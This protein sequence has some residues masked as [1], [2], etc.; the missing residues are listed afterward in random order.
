VN[1]RLP[2]IFEPD[3]VTPAW[4]REA[5]GRAVECVG[6]ELESIGTGQVGAN[7]RAHL[8][9]EDGD[10]PETVVIKFAASDSQS[11]STG[12][13]MGTYRREAEFYRLL[14]PTIEV[15]VPYVYFVDFVPGTADV[16]I[17]MED[18]EPRKQGDQLQGC[19]PEEAALA[20]SEAAKLH[21]AFWGKPELFDLDWVSRRTPEQ[22]TQ[23]IELMEILQPAFV[24]RYRRE[25]TEEAID[26]SDRFVRNASQWFSGLP[27]PATLVHGDFRLD[28]LMFAVPAAPISPRLVVVDWQTVTHSHGAHDVAY[29]V[30]SAFDAEDR[31]RCEQQLV[32]AYFEELLEVD[33]MP[34]MTF[35]EFWIHYRR[36]SWSGFIMAVLASM[37]VGRTDRGDE[38]FVTMANRHAS[39]V[40]D[41]EAVEFLNNSK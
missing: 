34:P 1:S 39:Q 9:W 32:S 11:R 26:V 7:Y 35:D 20:L 10:G 15:A 21:G 37:I 38:M 12:I 14:A 24:E 36:F 4:V 19:D 29:F 27:N 3:A 5:L 33:G 8:N 13:Q 30:G 23:T 31:R 17:V 18:L 22:V 2:P 28:N 40:V 41:L 25:L 6:C 16:V